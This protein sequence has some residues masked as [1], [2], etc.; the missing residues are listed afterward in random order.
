M[1]D[2]QA[3]NGEKQWVELPFVDKYSSES[4]EVKGC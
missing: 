4:L 1:Q 3:R 2:R